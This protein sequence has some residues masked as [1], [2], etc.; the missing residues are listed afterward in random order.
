MRLEGIGLAAGRGVETA[1]VIVIVTATGEIPNATEAVPEV[2]VVI[3][4]DARIL[5]EIEHI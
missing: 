3:V 4:R 2:G 5:E 1:I